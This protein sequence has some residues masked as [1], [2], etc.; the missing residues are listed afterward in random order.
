MTG[1]V[2]APFQDVATFWLNWLPVF[3]ALVCQ[4][5]ISKGGNGPGVRE[6]D[7]AVPIIILSSRG[8][9]AGKVLALDRGADN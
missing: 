9:K 5:S 3:D 6:G 1:R 8:D 2:I 7:N 4:A